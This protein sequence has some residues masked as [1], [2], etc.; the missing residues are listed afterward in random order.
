MSKPWPNT[1]TDNDIVDTTEAAHRLGVKPDTIHQW[2]QRHPNFPP[3]HQTLTIG[4][5]WK[6]GTI[7]QWAKHTGRTNP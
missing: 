5:I 4:P 7:R 2:R 3:P 1:H 6:W